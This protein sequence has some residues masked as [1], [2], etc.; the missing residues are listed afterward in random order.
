MSAAVGGTEGRGEGSAVGCDV[1]L[2][3]GWCDGTWV[4]AHADWPAAENCPLGQLAQLAA[5]MREE[6]VP[7]GQGEQSAA[8]FEAW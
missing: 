8:A 4:C 2:A 3:V 7:A 6:Y 5:P 1:G